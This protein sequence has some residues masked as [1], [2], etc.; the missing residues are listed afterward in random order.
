MIFSSR[1][2]NPRKLSVR[3]SHIQGHG[4]FADEALAKQDVII[5]YAG[6]V[7]RSILADKRENKYDRAGKSSPFRK[8]LL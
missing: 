1:K 6:E 8:G 4:L 7:I 3:R 2:N 5:E